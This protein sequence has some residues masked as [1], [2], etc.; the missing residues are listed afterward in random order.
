MQFFAAI[1][2]ML[3]RFR[4]PV[5]LP[6]DV[7]HSLGVE[8]DNCIGFK[9]FLNACRLSRPTRIAK[10]MPRMEAERAFHGA[11]RKERFSSSSLYSFYFNQGWLEFELQFDANSLL[12]RVYVHHKLLE[13]SGIYELQLPIEDCSHLQVQND[14]ADSLFIA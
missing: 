3:I 12:R 1:E 9:N 8:I 6:E 14:S 4:Y 2:R 13:G 5:S 10:F 7:A 11:L